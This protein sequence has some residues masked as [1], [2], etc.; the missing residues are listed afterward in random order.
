MKKETLIN[1]IVFTVWFIFGL[2][3]YSQ[4]TSSRVTWGNSFL[5][6]LQVWLIFHSKYN[7]IHLFLFVIPC[8][9]NFFKRHNLALIVKTV[10]NVS[11]R[12]VS[13]TP[14]PVPFPVPLAFLPHFYTF[15]GEPISLVFDFS[16][17]FYT[18]EQICVYFLILTFFI[19]FFHLTIYSE[20]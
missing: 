19:Y 20:N 2:M 14:R 11:L 5:H 15:C 13:D 9:F 3:G 17:S 6:P 10:Q 4:N 18:N 12:E 8:W 16:V 1:S 7:M